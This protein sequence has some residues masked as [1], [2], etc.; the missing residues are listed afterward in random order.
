MTKDEA[1]DEVV[2]RLWEAL[3]QNPKVSGVRRY[4]KNAVRIEMDECSID[5]GFHQSFDESKIEVFVK[6]VLARH[7]A[8][9]VR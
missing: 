1:K 4:G 9:L 3:G 6:A 8:L 7:H 5:T 2:R